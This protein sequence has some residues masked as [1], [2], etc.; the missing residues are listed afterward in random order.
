MLWQGDRYE[1][2]LA[3]R[4]WASALSG[5]YTVA[6]VVHDLQGMMLLVGCFCRSVECL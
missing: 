3:I 4:K 2:F 6:H 1:I 5:T